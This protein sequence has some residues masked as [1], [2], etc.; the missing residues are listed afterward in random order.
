MAR[1]QAHSLS[2]APRKRKRRVGRGNAS[3]KGTYASRGMKGQRARS[4]G[5]GGLQRRGF[6]QN[7]LKV[8]KL[9]GFVSL[10]PKKVT[11]TLSML[12]HAFDAGTVVTPSLMNKKGLLERHNE[13]AKIVASGELKKALTIEGCVA[14][15]A[16]V[17]AIE[18][19][20][21]KIVF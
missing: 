8:K 11:I 7:L 15:K 2:G 17:A 13:G 16:A 10:Q 6:K 12:E 3:T 9:R 18:K 1:L 4:G 19:A 14:T 21:G 5:K 20:G